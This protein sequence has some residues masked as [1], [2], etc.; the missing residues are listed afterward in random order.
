VELSRPGDSFGFELASV[1]WFLC[2]GSDIAT[3]LRLLQQGDER[4][5]VV[6]PQWLRLPREQAL[7]ALTA[8]GAA[9][10]RLLQHFM[11]DDVLIFANRRALPRAYLVPRV[12][13]VA[14]RAAALTALEG[15]DLALGAEAIVEGGPGLDGAG[16]P[17]GSVQLREHVA[18]RVVLD[19][20]GP[21]PAFL[22]LNDAYYPGWTATI[23][24]QPA[25]ILPANVMFR[26]VHVPAGE[27]RVVFR[28]RPTGWRWAQVAVGM[29]LALA[30]LVVWWSRRRAAPAVANG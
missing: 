5:T 24:D 15:R 16:A 13:V 23:D 18:D 1:R 14:D 22:V 8:D 19:V 20:Q 9:P 25:A 28:Y 3:G 10:A 12:R 6:H 21:A 29:S 17:I 7:A 30:V 26:G 4:W 27:H 2:M 11:A